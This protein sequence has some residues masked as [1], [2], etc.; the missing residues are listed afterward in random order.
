[1]SPSFPLPPVDRR[2]F[3][4][5]LAGVGGAALATAYALP[6]WAE[7]VFG[8]P[9]LAAAWKDQIGLQLFTVR[10]KFPTDYAG[11]LEAVAK[12]GYKQ[13]QPTMSYGGKTPAEVKAILDQNG[14]T[15]PTTHVSPPNG[16]DLEKTLDGYASMGHK[17]TTVNVGGEGRGRGGPPGGGAG[18]GSGAGAGAGAGGGAG[19]AGTPGARP[20]SSRRNAAPGETSGAPRPP[21]PPRAPAPPQTLDAVKR[22]AAALN[23]AGRITQKH[24]IKVIVHNHT[25][26]FG[27]LA[28]STQRPFDVLLA[29]TDPSLVAMELDIGWATVAGVKALDLFKQAPGRFEVWHVKDIAGLASLEGKN[30]SERQRAAQIVP[31]GQGEIDYKPIFAQA[32]AAGLK[33][34]YVEQDSAPASGDSIAAAAV[35]Y[36]ALLKTLS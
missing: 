15:A 7:S 3:I 32:S 19:A 31:V 20:D 35:S 1:M 2:S 22:T 4:R 17:Y 34:F 30:M 11:T 23:E 36:R 5:G 14:L 26:E 21:R 16:P 24:G 33:Y 8:D 29:E 28:D 9:A 25:V 12:I 10:D 6:A 27:P 18:G 13:V